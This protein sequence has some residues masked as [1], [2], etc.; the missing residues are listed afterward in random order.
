M[1][2]PRTSDDPREPTTTET[3]GLRTI[4]LLIDLVL[5]LVSRVT[6]RN[7]PV[8]SRKSPFAICLLVLVYAARFCFPEVAVI[9]L[10]R[11]L[12][13]V[14]VCDCICEGNDSCEK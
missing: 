9:A 5:A 12:G 6:I 8:T 1:N 10:F 13:A 11:T 2:P 14:A 3:G 7:T 4:S